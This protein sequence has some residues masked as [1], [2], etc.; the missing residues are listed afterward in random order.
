MSNEEKI[1]EMLTRMEADISGLKTDVSELKAVQVQQ[2][3]ALAEPKTVQDQHGETLADLKKTQAEQG[4]T[5]KEIDIRSKRTAVLLE[6]D[7]SKKINLLLEGHVTHTQTLAKDER[8]DKIEETVEQKVV[9]LESVVK[10][11]SE[12]I[13]KLEKAI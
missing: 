6:T 3:E 5:L 9:V 4:N 7:I 11:H 1:L 2:G 12:R 10:F 8:V 13:A